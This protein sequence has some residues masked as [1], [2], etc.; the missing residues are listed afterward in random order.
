MVSLRDGARVQ[1][2]GAR[3]PTLI[4]MG[5]SDATSGLDRSFLKA[6]C[7]GKVRASEYT[8]TSRTALTTQLDR[9]GCTVTGTAD[10][11]ARAAGIA[12]PRTGVRAQ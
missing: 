4:A 12:K 11:V 2:G 3:V 8:R 10:D 6:T 9:R 7:D 1:K 5:A